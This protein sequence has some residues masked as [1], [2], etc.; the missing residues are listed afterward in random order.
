MMLFMA[1]QGSPRYAK[2]LERF[3]VILDEVGVVA[4]RRAVQDR[5]SPAQPQEK[6][7]S[8]NAKDALPA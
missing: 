8:S 2:L 3:G 5:K 7:T 6:G 4:K 1:N